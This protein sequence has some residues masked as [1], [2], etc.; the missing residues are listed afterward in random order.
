MCSL[1]QELNWFRMRPL[2]GLRQ[3]LFPKIFEIS[4]C[5]GTFPKMTEN[6]RGG[7][8]KQGLLVST[9]ASS[10]NVSKPESQ[11]NKKNKK[12]KKPKKTKKQKKQKQKNK[13]TKKTKKP[14]KPKNQK[15]QKNKNTKKTKKKK[16][17][18][19]QNFWGL[20]YGNISHSSEF[21]FVFCFFGF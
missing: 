11:K 1:S 8:Q 15:K 3:I 14:K 13:K 5:F 19:N 18:K 9:R 10:T 12:P 17:T 4:D 7:C 21:F 6:A 20:V 2:R 16:T